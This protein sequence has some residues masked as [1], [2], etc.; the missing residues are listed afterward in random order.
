MAADLSTAAPSAEAAVTAADAAESVVAATAAVPPPVA[1]APDAEHAVAAVQGEQQ[2]EQQQQQQQ[3]FLSEGAESTRR[4][5]GY[6]LDSSV[7]MTE[8][9]SS[10]ARVVA[11]SEILDPK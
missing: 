6:P 1:A 10:A 9:M 3:T 4:Q 7:S 11:D 5:I 2:Q 8:R